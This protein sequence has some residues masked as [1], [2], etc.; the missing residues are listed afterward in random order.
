MAVSDETP[1]HESGDVVVRRARGRR[2]AGDPVER[3]S[4]STRAA[5]S[6]STDTL[7]E[8][9]LYETDLAARSPDSSPTHDYS[10]R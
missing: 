6:E 8:L 7:V 3:Q 4:T 9:E 5:A 1:D 2:D 10:I